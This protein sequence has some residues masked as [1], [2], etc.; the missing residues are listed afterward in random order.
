[1]R[2]RPRASGSVGDLSAASAAYCGLE[3]VLFR[4]PTSKGLATAVVAM[5]L[6]GI[7]IA[8]AVDAARSDDERPDTT[9]KRAEPS[10]GPTMPEDSD[11]NTGGEQ[12]AAALEAEGIA[13]VLYYSSTE[14]ECRIDA[15]ALPDLSAVPPPKLRACRFELPPNPESSATLAGVTWSPSGRVAATC[16]RGQ[17]RVMTPAGHPLYDFAGCAP[18]WKPNGKLTFVRKGEVWTFRMPCLHSEI[19]AGRPCERVILTRRNLA[20]AA[21]F[22]PIVPPDPRYVASVAATEL[23]WLSDT[24]TAVLLRV[25]L[26]GRLRPLGPVIVL[27]LYEGRR[28]L[29]T[30]AYAGATVLRVSPRRSFLAVIETDERISILNRSG[31]VLVGSSELPSTNERAIAWSP[32]ERWTALATRWS[33]FLIRNADIVAGKE[34]RTIRLPLVARDL[35]WR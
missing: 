15:M 34:P 2:S 9:E 24:R 10:S 33:V 31:R 32:D 3:A 23:A 12:L 27:A 35:A 22:H 4:R 18:V 13:G 30:V 29:K 5:A 25:R 7:G 26:R 19:E 21:R 8:A 1:M 17:V 11:E 16:R 6:V 20:K 28:L 14:D